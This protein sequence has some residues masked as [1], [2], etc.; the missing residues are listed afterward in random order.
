MTVV[1]TVTDMACKLLATYARKAFTAY[2]EVIHP[3]R[4]ISLMQQQ[5]ICLTLEL[6]AQLATI[7]KEVQVYHSRVQLVLLIQKSD[8]IHLR[9]VMNAL[10]DTIAKVLVTLFPLESARLD[11]TALETPLFPLNMRV[12]PDTTLLLG[13]ATKQLV[14]QPLT[15]WSIANHHARHAR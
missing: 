11:T 3:P 5:L 12:S 14:S 15:I 9:T 1:G 10:L 13:P 8:Q 2:L 4:L 7:V 6:S